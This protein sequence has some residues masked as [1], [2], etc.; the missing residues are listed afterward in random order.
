MLDL[1]SQSK[2]TQATAD[3]MRLYAC[4]GAQA[5]HAS[6]SHGMTVWMKALQLSAR[7]ADARW[8][9]WWKSA[10][11]AWEAWCRALEPHLYEER[12]PGRAAASDPGFSSYRSPGGHAVA[13]VVVADGPV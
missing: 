12:K 1:K 11:L 8:V 5:A 9:Q 7:S 3:L 6:A 13:Q 4:A 2:L 10:P